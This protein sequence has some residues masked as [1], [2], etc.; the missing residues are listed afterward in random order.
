[1]LKKLFNNQEQRTLWK[2]PYVRAVSEK[3]ITYTQRYLVQ[4][5]IDIVW[6]RQMQKDK[7]IIKQM[8]LNL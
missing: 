3:G 7:H 4:D 1:M 8:V 6:M 2:D 5:I